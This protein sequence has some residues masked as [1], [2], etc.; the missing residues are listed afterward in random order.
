MSISAKDAVTQLTPQGVRLI[1][2]ETKKNY[3]VLQLL[4]A[5][6]IVTQK[7]DN[8]SLKFRVF[9]SDGYC[10]HKA[11]L[12]N[13]AATAYEQAGSPKFPVVRIVDLMLPTSQKKLVLITKIEIIYTEIEE[14]IGNPIDYQDW[15]NNGGINK[16]G[17]N[18]IPSRYL[19]KFNNNA[20]KPIQNMMG[21]MNINGGSRVSQPSGMSNF[22]SNNSF[23]N[24][25]FGA[26]NMNQ[27][28]NRQSFPPNN[29]NFTS[30]FNKNG[31]RIGSENVQPN[32][33]KPMQASTGNQ[34]QFKK[35]GSITMLHNPNL[36]NISEDEFMSFKQLAP[37]TPFTIKARVTLKSA[38]REFQR[39]SDN[40]TNV[41]F[42][43]ELLDR[44]GN[45]ISATFFGDA[46]TQFYDLIEENKV[47]IMMNGNVKMA[48]PNFNRSKSDYQIIFDRRDA[49]IQ[50]VEDDAGICENKFNYVTIA[51][52]AQMDPNTMVDLAAF[53]RDEGM[54]VETATKNGGKERRN[55][56]LYDDTNTAIELTLWGE[57]A[58]NF[59]AKKDDLILVKAARIADF[60]GKRNLSNGYATRIITDSSHIP[61]DD[62]IR[63]LEE[64]RATGFNEANIQVMN[65]GDAGGAGKYGYYTLEEVQMAGEGISST[66]DRFF[67]DTRVHISHVKTEGNLYYAA[68][69]A[70][71]CQRKANPYGD[72]W[73]C[74]VCGHKMDQPNFRYTLTVKICDQSGSLWVSV[75]D[76]PAQ[77]IMGKD[78]GAI[79]ELRN[80]G[81]DMTLSD[82]FKETHNK[83]FF[84]RISVKLDEYNNQARPRYQ[85]V[86]VTPINYQAEN[87]EILKL[88]DEYSRL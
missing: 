87:R 62:R 33:Q 41:M 67:F 68:C 29:N 25:N 85:A 69:T 43:C 2:E 30:N 8:K 50:L 76:K 20:Q 24:N 1:V 34:P 78:A 5:E 84:M 9:I 79:N 38:K 4:D 54:S 53:V 63:Q 42:T 72:G 80:Q 40:S 65:G 81:D 17:A 74:S 45:E 28:V 60:N 82:I 49:V 22:S 6:P 55:V 12:G 16:E 26:G 35:S 88:L 37:F 86:K 39:K 46:V 36:A 11:V 13:E 7:S 73:E 3:V 47:Y 48:N 66:Q 19:P 56:W 52:I 32:V 61:I 31:N 10:H 57:L 14:K 51:Q 64:W 27:N 71:K 23:Q 21:Q 75:F 77:T 83:E 70:P 15:V 44:E 18:Q 59:N 58:T